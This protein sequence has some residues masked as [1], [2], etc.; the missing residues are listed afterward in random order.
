MLCG[1]YCGGLFVWPNSVGVGA[2]FEVPFH[3]WRIHPTEKNNEPGYEP[4]VSPVEDSPDLQRSHEPQVVLSIRAFGGC[5]F[6][7]SPAPPLRTARFGS[8]EPWP[9]TP[10]ERGQGGM[11]GMG[12]P[13]PGHGHFDRKI[14]NPSCQG[15]GGFFSPSLILLRC[16]WCL[17]WF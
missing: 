7:L 13:W 2:H 17:V 5:P 4:S 16:W 8:L 9:A 15:C 1:C 14:R 10:Q 11:R 12:G 6:R 3:Q